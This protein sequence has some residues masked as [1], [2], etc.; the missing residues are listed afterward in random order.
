MSLGS[1]R[2]FTSGK[3]L[4]L[5]SEICCARIFS[6]EK[7]ASKKFQ[8]RIFRREGELEERERSLAVKCLLLKLRFCALG[9]FRRKSCI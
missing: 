7:A 2:A 8:R 5:E 9:I 1:K 3:V 4:G 6:D